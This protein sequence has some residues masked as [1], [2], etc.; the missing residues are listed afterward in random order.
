M[1][2]TRKK[3]PI[4]HQ[5]LIVTC[6]SCGDVNRYQVNSEDQVEQILN[7][8]TC[9]NKCNAQY[10]SYILIGTIKVPKSQETVPVS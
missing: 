1:E 5:S 4:Q 2:K 6:E 3:D 8:Y 10:C 9:K 7:H